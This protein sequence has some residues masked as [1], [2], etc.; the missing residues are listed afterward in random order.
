[1]AG[2]YIIQVPSVIVSW[3]KRQEMAQMTDKVSVS[4]IISAKNEAEGITQIIESVKPYRDEVLVIDGHSTDDTAR[5]A[6]A[7]GAH[8]YQDNKRGKGDAYQVGIQ[9]ARCDVLVFIDADGSCDPADIP[10]LVKP[11]AQDEA[12]LVIASRHRG[13]S[14]EWGGDLNTF[15]RSIGSGFLAVVIN[16]RWKSNLTDVLYGYRAARRDAALRVPLRANDFD[17]EQHMIVQFLKHGYRVSEV[18][19]HEYCRK[20]GQSKLPT[21]RKAFLF[22][23]RLFL[24][25][26]SGK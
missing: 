24:D 23:G 21:Y 9:K 17:V 12:D 26:V 6:E 15:L 2:P 19:S 8:V 4:V 22:F 11:I 18:R 20:W 25:L 13:G 7:A 1:M 14:D 5:L 10:W 16:W 3:W